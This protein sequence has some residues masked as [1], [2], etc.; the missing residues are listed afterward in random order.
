[1]ILWRWRTR[2]RFSSCGCLPFGLIAVRAGVAGTWVH[3]VNICR[4]HN[5]QTQNHWMTKG[6]LS[7]APLLLI[8]FQKFWRLLTSAPYADS[9]GLLGS[10]DPGLPSST[11]ESYNDVDIDD[12]GDEYVDNECFHKCLCWNI[13][14][15][16]GG[17]WW[18]SWTSL[19]TLPWWSAWLC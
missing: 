19:A 2:W 12:D 16:F 14:C 1:M 4:L 7:A 5:A 11:E 13:L 18:S 6:L 15:L 10:F 3:S 9:L 8:I 17:I